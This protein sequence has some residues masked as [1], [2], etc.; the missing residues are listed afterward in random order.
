MGFQHTYDRLIS[1]HCPEIV[2]VDNNC[3]VGILIDVA[4][5]LLDSNIINK[6]SEKIDKYQDLHIELQR[7]W[8]LRTVKVILIIIGCL[9]TYMPNL[10]K[11]LKELPGKHPMAPLL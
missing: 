8:N 2:V 10:T 11:F 6:E 1:T 7:L 4:I 9:G 5:L 3:H